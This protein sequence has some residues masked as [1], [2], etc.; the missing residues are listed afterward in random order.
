M[1][2]LILAVLLGTSGCIFVDTGGRCGDGSRNGGETDVDCGGSSCGPCVTGRRCAVA[3]DCVTGT[4]SSGI[5]VD[6]RG[7]STLSTPNPQSLTI[8]RIAPGLGI[9]GIVPGTDIGYFITASTVNNVSTFRLTW[10]GDA[11]SSGTWRNFWGSVWT[12]GSVRAQKVGCTSDSPCPLEGDDFVSSPYPVQGGTKIDFDA[13]A[14]NGLDGF[15]F[16][17]DREPA[18]FDLYVDNRQDPSRV[19]FPALDGN[20]PGSLATSGAM[21]FGLNTR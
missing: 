3:A 21:P 11:S 19:F 8:Y 17:I 4:C 5:C 12:P 9:S 16:T 6:H 20:P 2:N 15:D 7:G 14:T 1:R 10:T 18:M 13:I